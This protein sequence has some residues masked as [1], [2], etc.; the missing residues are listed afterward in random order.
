MVIDSSTTSSSSSS[1]PS[2]SNSLTCDELENRRL[3]PRRRA[4]RKYIQKKREN[5]EYAEK[6]RQYMHMY[7]ERNRERINAMSRQ[8]QQN[9]YINNPE[10]REQYKHKLRMLYYKKNYSMSEEDAMSY[11]TTIDNLKRQRKPLN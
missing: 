1:S 9:K 11:I 8:N 5:P 10:L 4:Q 3:E 7:N 2:P 6:E